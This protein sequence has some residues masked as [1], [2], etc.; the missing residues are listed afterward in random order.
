MILPSVFAIEALFL[1]IA[2]A[3]RFVYWR[4]DDSGIHQHRLGLWNWDL[5]WTEIVSRTVGPKRGKGALLVNAILPILTGPYQAIQLRDR[6]GRKRKV[7]RAAMNGERLD[8]LVRYYLN[9]AEET[10]LAERYV[11][12]MDAAEARYKARETSQA[13]FEFATRES[14]VVR[15]KLHE[16]RIPSI[17]C[18][19]LGPAAAWLDSIGNF[20]RPPVTIVVPFCAGCRARIARAKLKSL[21]WAV[22][23]GITGFSGF[24]FL[25]LGCLGREAVLI[26]IG[27]V[28]ALVTLAIAWGERR[29]PS[30]GRLVQVVRSN[31]TEGW[32]EVRFGNQEYAR[33]VAELNKVGCERN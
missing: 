25:L 7:N 16:P 10:E 6:G 12:V 20:S 8:A 13:P 28:C 2:A 4:I 5:P 29:V 27:M 32:M 19:C 18:N 26:V 22:P 3:R 11:H 1:T 33:L 14:P 24:F 15:L 30:V 31:A 9:P 21:A 23:G 17:C